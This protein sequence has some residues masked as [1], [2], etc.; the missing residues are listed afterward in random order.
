MWTVSGKTAQESSGDACEMNPNFDQSLLFKN[1]FSCIPWHLGGRKLYYIVW[2]LGK[3]I[4]INHESGF[5]WDL[6]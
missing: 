1:D 3:V 2:D 4:M 5:F 6:Y